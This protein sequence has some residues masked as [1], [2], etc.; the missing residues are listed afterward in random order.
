[1]END[2][3]NT[4]KALS[5]SV[6]LF[7]STVLAAQTKI[8]TDSPF[9][10]GTTV[11]IPGAKFKRSGYHNL[12]WGRHYRKEWSTPVRVSNFYIDTAYG[13]LTP[14]AESGSRQSQG[15]RLKSGKG[16]E[17]V[18]RSV[19]KD[20]GRAFPDNFQKTF[21]TRVAKDQASIAYPFAAITITPMIQATG[22][23]HTNPRIIFVPAQ[24]PLSDYNKKYG[25]QLYLFEERADENQEDADYFGNSKNVIGSE[26]LFEHIYEDNDNR[27]DQKAFA[28]A[29]LFDMF[30]GDWG[31]HPDNWRWAKFDDGNLNIYRP[32]PRDRDQAY[33]KLDGFWPW[34]GI[35]I[36]GATHL[37]TFSFRIHNVK[38]FNKPAWPLDRPF[39]NELTQQDWTNA[40]QQLQSALTDQLIEYSIHQLPPELFSISGPTI[41]AK[42]KSRR[43]HLQDYAKDYYRFLSHH[44]ELRG[45]NDREF[46]E[47]K[48][49]NNAETQINIYKITKE[50]EIKKKPYYSRTFFNKETREVR[51]YSLDKPD[52]IQVTGPPHGVKVRIID[53]DGT[54][55][56]SREAK[57]RTKLSIGK[58][59]KF[60]TLHTKKFDFFILPLFSPPEYKVFEDDPMGLFTKT[61]ARI[62]VN[63]RY[64]SQP[65]RR[66]QY[67][68]SHVL[69]ANYGFLRTAFNIGYIG[70]FNHTVGPFDFLIKARVDPRAVE[71]YFGTGNETT[72]TSSKRNY[73][74]TFTTRFYGGL[75][76]S[77]PI[78]SQQAIDISGFY[79]SIKVD[80]TAG[81]FISTDH[82]IDPSLFNN[83]QF[84]GAELAYR[85]RR[86]NN[87]KFPTAGVDFLLAGDYVQNLKETDRS[88]TNVVS[89][90]SVYIPLGKAFSIA[91][92]A[93]GAALTGDAD[94]YHL[95]KLGGYVNL[96]GYDRERFSGKTM[97]YN[98]NELRWVVNTK[99][100]FFNGEIGLLAFYDDGRV[101]Q[102]LE[103][104]DKWHTGY[105]GGLILIPFNKLVLTGTYCIS[106][107]AKFLQLKAGLF[108]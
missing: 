7:I 78:K 102:P 69:S 84:A 2:F 30:I 76:L 44:V 74:R 75:G 103:K 79:Q 23:Y 64:L 35:N 62:S 73:N 57:G 82:G 40:A 70:R 18:L 39:T 108:F 56:I 36:A 55:S 88:F 33:T 92:K 9:V 71:N 100:Y 85:F 26:K 93:G 60:D 49:L 89:S 13:G 91:S 52:I 77:L 38:K 104:S 98:N 95:N 80:K 46:F 87:E 106:E 37:E 58:K 47:V 54:D 5:V 68:K 25:N 19:D 101:W 27:V 99:N 24:G 21:I 63:M 90:L 20:F 31:R 48:R 59:F 41:I 17:Y 32:V 34:V 83:R 53:P 1:M 15:L 81:H 61:G 14:T 22:I 6:L 12:F 50:N 97:F 42:L 28:K 65:W 67:M 43:N 45:S 94:F 8:V 107:E 11:V 72:K 3:F 10:K 51:L 29:R 86:I 105:G 16:K 4:R 66:Q 96:R